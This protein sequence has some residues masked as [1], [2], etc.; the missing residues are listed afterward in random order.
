M[1]LEKHSKARDGA[2]VAAVCREEA[3]G[4]VARRPV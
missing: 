1:Y 3:T 4:N 2:V